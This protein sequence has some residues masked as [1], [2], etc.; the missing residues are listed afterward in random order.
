MAAKKDTKKILSLLN[1]KLATLDINIGNISLIKCKNLPDFYKNKIAL[2]TENTKFNFTKFKNEIFDKTNETTLFNKRKAI[3]KNFIIFILIFLAFQN[4][5]KCNNICLKYQISY[6]V[7]QVILKVDGVGYK[8]ILSSRYYNCP[9]R[10]YINGMS[11]PFNS[12][13]CNRVNVENNGSIITLEWDNAITTS[14]NMFESCN[15]I[16]EIDMTNFNTSLVKTMKNTFERCYNLKSINLKFLDTSNVKSFEYMF[17]LCQSLKSIDVSHF[18]TGSTSVMSHM[19]D[20]CESLTILDISN[21]NTKN[22]TDMSSMFRRCYKL[23]S[24]NLE[25]FDTSKVKTFYRMFES[26]E[27]LEVLDISNFNTK[28]AIDINQMFIGTYKLKSIN[29]KNFKENENENITYDSFFEGIYEDLIICI[30]KVKSPKIS[31][32]IIKKY[33]N[34]KISCSE[35]IETDIKEYN[36]IEFDNIQIIEKTENLIIFT[37][38]TSSH[39]EP[40]CENLYYLD[41]DGNYICLNNTKCQEEFPYLMN[42]QCVHNCSISDIIKKLCKLN[43]ENK[44]NNKEKNETLSN[45][46]E[47]KLIE[48][49]KVNLENGKINISKKI[50]IENSESTLEIVKSEELKS[51]NQKKTNISSLD[52]GEC[53]YELKRIY[54]ISQND[55]LIIFKLD[56]KYKKSNVLKVDYEVYYKFENQTRLTKLNLS[57]CENLKIR[58]GLPVNKNLNLKNIDILNPDSLFYSDIC[59]VYTSDNGADITLKQRQIEY[60][61]KALIEP[62][63]KVID[64]NKDLEKIYAVCDIKT[65][66]ENKIGGYIPREKL[67]KGFFDFKNTL[68]IK[69]FKCIDLIFTFEVYKENYA[70]DILVCVLILYFVI[71]IMFKFKD[72]NEIIKF[73]DFIIYF[74]LN[75]SKIEL[76]LNKMRKELTKK[77]DLNNIDLN[78]N[79]NNCIIIE[80]ELNNNKKQKTRKNRTNITKTQNVNQ[81]PQNQ[82]L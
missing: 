53:E 21:F 17:Y 38:I 73:R 71:M 43:Y 10:I 56:A 13:N 25:N 70:N 34:I 42:K 50:V 48:N 79:N 80:N 52:F 23:K 65:D 8:T 74:R 61:D 31:N 51:E 3:I 78:N 63:C 30:N 60:P 16:I 26:C 14:D 11:I 7:N 39:I 35:E 44:N 57:Y 15:D 9:S 68:N 46:I 64:Y 81:I 62:N 20:S 29:L 49:I 69:V 72:Y 66:F 12:N 77:N 58:L 54:N 55:S 76:I 41:K 24:I 22:V 47:E 18:N 27:S 32:A 67:I 40:I 5:P 82:I 19:F 37:H 2:K 45:K 28:N 36:T 75:P 4:F 33:T 59:Y 1:A 6:K